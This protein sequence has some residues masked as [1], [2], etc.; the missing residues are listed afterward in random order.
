MVWD[1]GLR[2]LH[3]ERFTA[4]TVVAMDVRGLVTGGHIVTLVKR[5]KNISF[6]LIFRNTGEEG[7]N[8][9]AVFKCY[10]KKDGALAWEF[11]TTPQKLAS[12]ET[13]EFVARMDTGVLLPM[14]Y[15]IESAGRFYTKHVERNT[16]L[17]RKDFR[18]IR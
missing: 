1:S 8:A 9:Y 4:G 15:F 16:R 7:L 14:E 13:V 10:K 6:S 12:N 3:E 18:V 2:R 11:T 5:G 17:L